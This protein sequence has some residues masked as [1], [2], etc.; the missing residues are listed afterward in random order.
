MC[1]NVSIVASPFFRLNRAI[2]AGW[3][4]ERKKQCMYGKGCKPRMRLTCLSDSPRS[5]AEA[6]A[7][8]RSKAA[9]QSQ[10]TVPAVS[11]TPTH[12]RLATFP[13]HA[14]L[15]SFRKP[16]CTDS[17]VQTKKGR[18]N[19]TYI[20]AHTIRCWGENSTG[21]NSTGSTKHV[22]PI[23]EADV[24]PFGTSGEFPAFREGLRLFLLVEAFGN[25]LIVAF[26]ALFFCLFFFDG[27]E[28]GR[29]LSFF[30]EATGL[31]ASGAPPA[32]AGFLVLPDFLALA[33]VVA[34]ADGLFLDT[35]LDAQVETGGI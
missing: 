16:S 35:F 10:L 15:L 30:A 11:A 12:P 34:V 29:L 18:G 5:G 25:S 32:W 27:F 22:K 9:R 19:D 24:P 1:G 3:F 14:L 13:V 21:E 26:L 33:A 2:R 28:Q 23:D 31:R 8:F 6:S 7:C 17:T 20:S 4:P